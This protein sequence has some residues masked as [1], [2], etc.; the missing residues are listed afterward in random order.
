M[1][2]SS[3]VRTSALPQ[4]FHH[5][6]LLPT[7]ASNS[8]PPESLLH[9]VAN[10]FTAVRY[11]SPNV[12]SPLVLSYRANDINSN[13]TQSHPSSTYPFASASA[14]SITPSSNTK[15]VHFAPAL[16]RAAPSDANDHNTKIDINSRNAPD[17]E[18]CTRH[19]E[20]S[21]PEGNGI[22]IANIVH[23]SSHSPVISKFIKIVGNQPLI[24]YI[25]WAVVFFLAIR[26]LFFNPAVCPELNCTAGG[27]PPT[28]ST[29][30]SQRQQQQNQQQQLN[31]KY[32]AALISLL[33]NP[34]ILPV[35]AFSS[36]PAN[37]TSTFERQGGGAGD[38]DL[39][40]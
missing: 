25:I 8:S 24:K 26:A 20:R 15:S 37:E 19:V 17:T 35:L 31:Q 9:T 16:Y 3:A 1:Q 28:G 14:H 22:K 30:Y 18:I 34:K 40:L 5:P 29:F 36:S 2:P 6:N 27:V 7:S 11:I 4:H 21:I 10:H 13:I 23:E 38:D 32:D 39:K 33:T 12:A